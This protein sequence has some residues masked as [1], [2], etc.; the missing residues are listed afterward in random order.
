MSDHLGGDWPRHWTGKVHAMCGFIRVDGK[1]LR[2]LGA[3]PEVHDEATQTSLAVRATQSIYQFTAHGVT[4]TVTFTAPLLLADLDLMSRPANYITFEVV[5]ADGQ[6]HSV[7]IYFDATAEWA[8]NQP[9]EQVEWGRAAAEGLD[10]MRIGSRY[11]RVLATKGDDVRID[12]GYFY[13]A[14]PRGTAGTQIAEDKVARS[15]FAD[16]RAATAG[17][18]GQMPRAA[19]DRW[20]VLSAVFDL[21]RVEKQPVRRHVIVAYDDL[22]AVEYFQQKLRAWWRRDEGMS[23]EKMLAAA[24]KDYADVLRRCE[25]FD[26]QLAAAAARSGSE[27]Y[28]RLCQ[29]AYRQAVAAHKL[30]AGPD[31][32]P[33]FFSKENFSNGSIGTVDV[34]Y[35]SAPL[36]LL[37][38]PVL[39]EGMMD[40]IF[41]F[42]E[43]GRWKKPFAAHDVGTYP[44]ANGQTYPEDMPVEECGNM[45]ILAAAIADAQGNAEYA[46]RHWQP[47][48]TWA[49]Y[50]RREGFDPANQLCTD[51]FAGHLAHNANLSIKAILGLGSYGK[52]AGSLGHKDLEKQYLELARRLATKWTEAAAAGDHTSLTFDNKNSWSQKYN[53]VWDRLLGLNLF[54]PEVAE[55]EIAFYLKQQNPFGLPLDSRKSYTKSDWILWTASMARAPDDFQALIH[56]VYRFVNE[57][58]NRVPL[59]DWHE[60][61]DGRVVG[62][63]ARSVVGG[64]FMKMLVDAARQRQAARGVSRDA[65]R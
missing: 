8:V 12:W 49:E 53:L 4:L 19:S 13:V 57:G 31:G 33:L 56:P 50:L 54:G 45:L 52:L 21:G 29:L 14:V 42:A 17:D 38:N 62:F 5:S 51:D 30:V 27:E 6:P 23:A 1:P 46:K 16:A 15:A 28:T 11:Q 48:S 37:Y 2:F 61:T 60:T 10:A 44:L 58:R 41:Y 22:F 3:A 32:R 34:T 43:S 20:P 39:V 24:E 55:K 59:S 25:E 63:R 7:Q 36:F 65:S 18:D 47:L 40:P 64:Y 35:P 26:K 9:Q